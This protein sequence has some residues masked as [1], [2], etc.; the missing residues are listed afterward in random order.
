MPDTYRV[1]TVVKADDSVPEVSAASIVAKVARDTYMVQLAQTYASYGF[2]AH[3]GYGTLRHRQA[4][5]DNG[6]TPEHRKSF[7]MR[8][9]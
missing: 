1:T 6:L 2:D 8:L 3:V 5:I 4:I 9:A 7:R